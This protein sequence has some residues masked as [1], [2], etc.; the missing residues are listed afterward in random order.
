M[1]VFITVRWLW[2]S[3]FYNVWT[4]WSGGW[5]M[6]RAACSSLG[7]SGNSDYPLDSVDTHPGW[8]W[9]R[10]PVSCSPCDPCHTYRWWKSWLSTK[11]N[12]K[13]HSVTFCWEEAQDSLSMTFNDLGKDFVPARHG[14]KSLFVFFWY[15]T[16]SG[17]YVG[18]WIGASR[19]SQVK[20]NMVGFLTQCLLIG[21]RV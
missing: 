14:W 15:H 20:G 17:W 9:E 18:G 19:Y 21:V 16:C 11:L 5:K 3:S 7:S 8:E 10:G 13:G 1:R 6:E 2:E 4:E 12:G